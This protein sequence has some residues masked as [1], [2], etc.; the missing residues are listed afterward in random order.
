MYVFFRLCCFENLM[1]SQYQSG[2]PVW[3]HTVTHVRPR[4]NRNVSDTLS[5]ESR[6][7][8]SAGSGALT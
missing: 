3:H 2:V 8:L 7:M 5:A 6:A 4:H 1:R